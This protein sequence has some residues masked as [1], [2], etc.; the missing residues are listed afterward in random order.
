MKTQTLNWNDIT[1]P[2]EVQGAVETLASSY[3]EQLESKL[4]AL[5]LYGSGARGHF[6]EGK[7]DV[8]LLIVVD[9]IDTETLSSIFDST[10]TARRHNLAPLFM[11][12]GDLQSFTSVFPIKFLSMKESYRVLHGEDAIASL[13]VDNAH[14]RLRCQQEMQNL[15]MRL[16][17]HFLNRQGH[18]LTPMLRETLNGFMEALRRVVQLAQGEVPARKDLVAQS[19]KTVGFDQKKLEEL[20]KFKSPSG[21]QNSEVTHDLFNDFIQIVEQ[22]ARFIEKLEAH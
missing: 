14:L 21:N 2:D 1:L 22:T 19:A 12:P 17:R 18:G 16:R 13:E 15:L 20:M 6:R 9:S 3:C 8:N 5:I 11:T 4:K 10:V 7:S